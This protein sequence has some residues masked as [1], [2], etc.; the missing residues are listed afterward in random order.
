[1]NCDPE[2]SAWRGLVRGMPGDGRVRRFREQLGL[3][4]DRPIIMAGHQAQLWHPG[5]LVKHLAGEALAERLGGVSV[6][7]VVDQ[8]ANE[9]F[10]FA[11]PARKGDEPMRRVELDLL[12]PAQRGGPKRPTG[13]R[14]AIRPEHPG[15]TGVFDD[16]LD[17]LVEA[18]AERA[19]ESSAA[20]QVTQALFDWLDGIIARPKLV[21]ASRIAE[22]DL[23]QSLL[24]SAKQ[25]TEAWSAGFNLAVD[26]VPGSGAG[27]LRA[28][29]DPELPMWRLDGRG[30]RVRARVSDLGS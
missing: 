2:A 29:E 19:G 13:L 1:M 12:P 27:R 14:P 17:A 28:G 18:V 16:R 5:I 4:V 7:L 20:A 21:F 9:P 8:D 15:R 30:R 10:Q 25:D 23:F 26:A 6:W 24:E 22:T 3:P 11:A